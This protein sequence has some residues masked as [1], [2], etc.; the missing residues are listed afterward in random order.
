METLLQSA[1]FNV[2]RRMLRDR[3][4]QERPR[5]FVAHP[6]AVVVLPLLDDG[7]IV[8]LHQYRASI[9]RTL[10]ELPAGTL[11]Q[12]GESPIQAAHRELEE[13]AG[14]RAARMELLTRF[15]PSPGILT[16]QMHVYVATGLTPTVARP[17]PGEQIEVEHVPFDDAL[18]RVMCGE[19][20][21]AKSMV[22]LLYFARRRAAA[23]AG[24][25]S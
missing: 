4:G 5:D 13:E 24:G 18:R 20:Q 17:E 14:Y 3:D 22:T 19:I 25:A 9:D 11:D 2:V 12:P 21:D 8:L 23:A 7:R 15:Y 6:G 1:K 10:Q 16:E